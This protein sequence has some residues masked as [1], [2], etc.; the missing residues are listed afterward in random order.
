MRLLHLVEQDDGVRAPANGLGELTAL[1]VAHV[2][3]G[4]TDEALHAELFHVLRHVDAHERALVVEQTLGERLGQLGLAHAGG[5]QKEEAADGLVGIGESGAAAAHGGGHGGHGLVLADHALVQLVLESLELVELALHH[6]G[7]GHARPRAHDLGDLVGGHLLVERVLALFLLVERGLGGLDL[8]R[9]ARDHAKAQLG[10]A[11]EVAVARGALL[12]ALGVVKLAFELLYVVDGVLLV[13]PAGLL[14]VELF[15]HL[16]D[17]LAQRPQALL[18]GVVGLLH[19][20]LL[21]DLELRELTRDGVDLDRHGVELHAQTTRSLIDQV[22]G[23]I[24]QKAVGDVAV[25]EVGRRHKRPVGDVHTMEDLVLLFE[26]AQ[27]R[28]GVFHRGLAH[29]HGLEATRQRGVLLDVLAVL[30]ER[31]GADG[32]ELA[33]GERGLEDIACVHGALGGARAHDRVELVDKENHLAVGLLDLFEHSFKAILELTAVLGT[34]HKRAHVE[35]DEVAVA[36]GAR[37]VARNDALGDALHDGG[38]AHARLADEHGIVLGAAAQHLNGATDLV[39]T[40]DHRVEL[41]GAR[42]VADVAA[43]LL[44]RL[45]LRL[46]VGRGHAVVAPELRVHLLNAV[47]GGTGVPEDPASLVLALGKS[48]EQVLGGHK[49]VLHLGGL[50]LGGVEHAHEL[51]GEPDLPGIARNLGRRLHGFLHA[52]RKLRRVGP[53]ALDDHADVALR[54]REQGREQVDRLHAPRLGIG[55]DTHSRLQ[56]LARRHGQLIDSHTITSLGCCRAQGTAAAL[57][58]GSSLFERYYCPT[59]CGLYTNLSVSV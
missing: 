9:E 14:H 31:G 2:S 42:E 22:D 18:R 3:R 7:H 20:R 38:L 45:E 32:V 27:D 57:R 10:G 43:I 56:R 54:R 46:A 39:G 16:G 24:G 44:E 4:R 11:G 36:Q 30:V 59:A 58:G 5:S 41:A 15:L 34:G 48:H 23:L 8:L 50:F 49:A 33:A 13:E 51:V 35:L 37:H 25:R 17:L 29:E 12:L 6:L 28:D 47:L 40:A 1:V 55:C 21:L 26:P 52:R 19:E 53:D